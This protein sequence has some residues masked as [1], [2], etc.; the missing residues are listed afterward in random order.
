MKKNQFH[1]DR[2][3]SASLTDKE[4]KRILSL[5]PSK[6]EIIK[7]AYFDNY[8]LPCPIKVEIKTNKGAYSSVVLRKARHGSVDK[9]V[10]TIR[11]LKKIGLLVP[12]VLISP[13][14]NEKGERV[15]IYSLLPGVNLQKLSMRSKSGQRMAV[16]LLISAVVKLMSVTGVIEKGTMRE[17]FPRLSVISELRKVNKKNSPWSKEEIFIK[18]VKILNKQFVSIK[19]PLVFTNG[20]YQPGNFLAENNKITGYLDFESPSFQDPLMGFVKYPIYDLFPLSRTNVVDLFLKKKGFTKKD[21]QPRLALGCLKILQKEIPVKGG[22]SEM[23]KYRNRVLSL[24]KTA[25]AAIE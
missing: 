24:L 12:D 17:P 7:V 25:L 2:E 19:E 10:R 22:D 13:F 20:D 4:K 14:V 1:S 21:F 3:L 9:E 18:A 16:R 6:S 11:I 23:I 15:A 5:Y 8:D